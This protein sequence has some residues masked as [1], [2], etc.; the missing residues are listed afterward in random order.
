MMSAV[1]AGAMISSPAFASVDRLDVNLRPG[2]L[3][4]A[5]DDLARSAHLQVLYDP[6]LVRGRSTEGLKGSMT[7]AQAIARLLDTT[8][9]GFTF[10]AGDAVAL[11]KKGQPAGVSR[12]SRCR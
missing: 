1:L 8:D 7:L 12:T 10:T 3:A 6:D 9:L 2:S 5:L 11:Y 4:Q